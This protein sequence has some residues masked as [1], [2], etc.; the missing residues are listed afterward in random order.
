MRSS[1][2]A[3]LTARSFSETPGF[4]V[5]IWTLA[6]VQTRGKFYW[7][8]LNATEACLCYGTPVMWLIITGK[9]ASLIFVFLLRI[10][11]EI[12]LKS[13]LKVFSSITK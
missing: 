12:L 3:Q 7:I 13:K 6:V 10:K 5:E 8:S 9:I 1:A 11:V 2:K 4:D